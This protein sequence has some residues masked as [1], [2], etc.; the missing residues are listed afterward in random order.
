M[1]KNDKAIFIR[2]P[3]ELRE[4]AEEMA[5]E[6]ERPV[7]WIIRKLLEKEVAKR[8]PKQPQLTK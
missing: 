8:K 1:A 3:K 2:L 4:Q 7:A 6:Q 5:A